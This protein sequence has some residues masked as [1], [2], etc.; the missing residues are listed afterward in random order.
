MLY[1]FRIFFLLIYADRKEI[2]KWSKTE[3]NTINTN[4][5]PNYNI[6]VQNLRLIFEE[7]SIRFQSGLT[8]SDIESIL[9]FI[10]FIRFVVLAIRYNL[11]TSFYISCIGLFAGFL[12]YRHLLDLTLIYRSLLVKVPYFYKLGI[13]A[14]QSNSVNRGMGL[15]DRRLGENENYYNPI[16]LIYYAY[17]RAIV[18]INFETG[19]SYYIDPISMIISKLNESE[20]MK[21]LPI[22]YKIYTKILPQIIE[23]IKKFWTQFSGIAAYAIITRIGKRYCPYLIRWHWT[24]LLIIGFI[25]QIIIHFCYRIFYFQSNVLLPITKST[26]VNSFDSNVIVQIN[27]LNNLLSFI[28]CFHIGLVLFGLFHAV[29]GQYFYFPFLVENTELHI[30]LRPKNSIYSGGYTGWQDKKKL[31]VKNKFKLPRLWYGWF[32]RGIDNNFNLFNIFQI[33]IKNFIKKLLRLT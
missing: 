10:V 14:V 3:E 9:F 6:F 28:I 22:Y 13:D 25:E 2:L 1:F 21:I 31:N 26:T 16:Q 23:V 20:K 12:W 5:K 17:L 4:L 11:K 18:K 19:F 24:F 8:L 7:F 29:C 27:F 15:T 33:S 32:G 30:G